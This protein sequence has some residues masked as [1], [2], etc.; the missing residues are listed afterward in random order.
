[1]II[2]R[3]KY[4]LATDYLFAWTEEIISEAEN[5]G[6]NVN[7]VEGSD[8]NFKNFEKRIKKLQPKFIFF[9]GHGSKSC[10]YDNDKIELINLESSGLLKDTITFV[11]PN[12]LSEISDFSTADAQ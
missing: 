5:K 12:F 6:Y 8:V 4:D 11:T 1:M 2:V 7:K 10:L 3:T 9:N